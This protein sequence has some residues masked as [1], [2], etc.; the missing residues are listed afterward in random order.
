MSSLPVKSYSARRPHWQLRAPREPPQ[1]LQPLLDVAC[2]GSCI[3][4]V[5]FLLLCAAERGPP[6]GPQV[7]EELLLL[8]FNVLALG[9]HH[10]AHGSDPAA[11]QRM[12]TALQGGTLSAYPVREDWNCLQ[13]CKAV[14]EALASFHHA[15]SGCEPDMHLD[16]GIQL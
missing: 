16:P 1:S 9:L 11:V 6:G 2:S 7:G 15:N 12:T 3:A 13:L 8:A 14:A 4:L 10:L 5:H